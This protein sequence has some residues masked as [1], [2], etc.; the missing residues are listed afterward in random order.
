MTQLFWVKRIR[1]QSCYT[2]W[3]WLVVEHLFKV[4]FHFKTNKYSPYSKT[5]ISVLFRKTCH[6]ITVNVIKPYAVKNFKYFIKSDDH[7]KA[8]KDTRRDKEKYCLYFKNPSCK[9]CKGQWIKN[10]VYLKAFEVVCV[11]R[12]AAEYCLLKKKEEENIL[13]LSS[14]PFNYVLQLSVFCLVF[15]V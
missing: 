10:C 9:I 3:P 1:I 2:F 11:W 14:T 7:A 4:N 13:I 5:W 6:D 12:L 8:A 15:T